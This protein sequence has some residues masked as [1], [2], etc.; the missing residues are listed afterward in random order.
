[1]KNISTLLELAGATHTS[2]DWSKAAL[3]MIDYQQEYTDGGLPLGEQ[4]ATCVSNAIELMKHARAHNSPVIHV[5]HHGSAG[6]S[7][8]N[9]EN[10]MVNM[11]P[12]IEPLEDEP[13]VIKRLPNAFKN[14]N[15]DDIIALTDRTQLVLCGFMSH[16]CISS[17]VRASLDL[18]YKNY[19]CEDACFTRDLPDGVGGVIPAE[20]VHRNSIAALADR[21]SSIETTQTLIAAEEKSRIHA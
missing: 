2:V 1:M 13:I 8:F 9:P 12:E 20:E 7:L 14:T 15:L 17:T 11:I 6:G 10:K 21:F 18:G 5:L 19:V 4:A 3:I 16:M